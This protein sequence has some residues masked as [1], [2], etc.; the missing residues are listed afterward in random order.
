M[1]LYYSSAYEF[2]RKNL[3]GVK[4][5]RK[6][7]LDNLFLQV[8]RIHSDAY[9][10]K[11]QYVMVDLSYVSYHVQTLLHLHGKLSINL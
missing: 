4:Q 11:F 1:V 5:Q 9:L 2:Q 7:Y 3:D 10:M 8:L 6:V